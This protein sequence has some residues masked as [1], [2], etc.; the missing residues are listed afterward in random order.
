MAIGSGLAGQWGVVADGTYATS[1]APTRFYRITKASQKRVNNTADGGG[2]SAGQEMAEQAQHVLVSTGATGSI[3]AP[4]STNSWGLIL[5]HIFGGT[6]TILQQGATTAWLQSFAPG[7]NIG[8]SFTSQVGV[9]NRGGTVLPYTVLGAKITAATFAC[10]A[11]GLLTIALTVDGQQLV[12]TTALATAS[13]PANQLPFHFGDMA[14]K[15]GTFGAEAAVQGVKGITLTITRPQQTD[16][17]YYAGNSTTA[18]VSIKSEPVWNDYLDVSGSLDIDVVNKADFV[19]RFAANTATSML[20]QWVKTTAIASTFFPTLSFQCPATFFGGDT[21]A[22]E[23]T[24]VT[25]VSVPFTLRKDLTNGS[26][27]G[28]Y[29]SSDTTI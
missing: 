8:K 12:E 27:L 9:P 2:I 18:G 21:P 17:S 20:V 5:A 7:D 13:F 26:I 14:V 24:G 22:L 29:M 25:G 3:E 4:F 19:D 28:K 15:L 10:Q 23:D 11:G 6:P 16:D 1:Q